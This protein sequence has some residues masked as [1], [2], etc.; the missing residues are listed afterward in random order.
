[1]PLKKPFTLPNYWTPQQAMAVVDLLDDLRERIW[2]IY[3]IQLL[4]AYRRDRAPSINP[5]PQPTFE[6]EAPF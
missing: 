5:K 1:M 4:D 6:D 3:R 2:A